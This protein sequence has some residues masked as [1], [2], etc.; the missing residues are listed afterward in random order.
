[1]I[2]FFFL[3][4]SVF[5]LCVYKQTSVSCPAFKSWYFWFWIRL[6]SEH[7]FCRN[8][9]TFYPFQVKLSG[10]LICDQSWQ[11]VKSVVLLWSL[12]WTSGDDLCSQRICYRPR[13]L[14]CN[15]CYCT[16]SLLHYKFTCKAGLFSIT[17]SV[18][19]TE[20]ISLFSQPSPVDKCKEGVMN[21]TNATDTWRA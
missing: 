17:G 7:K 10:V 5:P 19:I 6:N 4:L 9:P 3:R 15:L 20:G 12:L 18:E 16:F 14:H 8:C 1:M 13:S 21:G 2:L 11:G